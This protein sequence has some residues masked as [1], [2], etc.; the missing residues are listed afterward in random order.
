MKKEDDV[1]EKFEEIFGEY[2]KYENDNT[3]SD[4]ELLLKG[5]K[6]GF[7]LNKNKKRDGYFGMSSSSEFLQMSWDS[8]RE[9]CA[10][11]LILSI[12]KGNFQEEFSM[13]V[14]MVAAWGIYH[15]KG[16]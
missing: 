12:G 13:I 7:N 3:T 14:R 8:F 4:Y 1:V 16:L 10:G 11:R 5:F 9:Y 15:D 6:G 2:K